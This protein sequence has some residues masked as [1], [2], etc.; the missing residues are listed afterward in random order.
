MN[1]R[2]VLHTGV[3]LAIGLAGCLDGVGPRSPSSTPEPLS[4]PSTVPRIENADFDGEFRM[5]CDAPTESETDASDTT[6][7]PDA[8]SASLPNAEIAFTLT[9]RRD[10]PFNANFYRWELRKRVDGEWHGT[11]PTRASANAESSLAPDSSHT[12]SV[13]I[14]NDALGKPVEPVTADASLSLRALGGGTYSFVIVG[15]YGRRGQSWVENQPIVA[16][17]APFRLE[18]DALR[19]VPTNAVRNVAR[20]GSA[21]TVTVGADD[22]SGAITVTKRPSGVDG[23]RTYVTE[24]VY[25]IPSLRNAL[26]QFEDGV[27]EVTV[28]TDDP[29]GSPLYRGLTFTYEGTAYEVTERSV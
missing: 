9:N 13:S 7:A 23:G 28:R 8:R 22:P 4:C 16:Y 19:L 21:V 5:E 10:R 18:G 17:A 14:R 27:D 2:T 24:S 12:W 1:R 29:F 15:S 6:L 25:G 3:A 20:D 11:V 26:A